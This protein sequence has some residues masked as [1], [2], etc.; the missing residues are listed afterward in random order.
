[1]K[2]LE[3][4]PVMPIGKDR[5]HAFVDAP[6]LHELR[7]VTEGVYP[8]SVM[9]ET[10]RMNRLANSLTIRRA[11][12]LMGLN[13]VEYSKLERGQFTLLEEDWREAFARIENVK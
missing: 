6:G 11:A 2:K 10:L 8:R 1:M 13:V 5:S 3:L 7:E 9:S 12:P 4:I